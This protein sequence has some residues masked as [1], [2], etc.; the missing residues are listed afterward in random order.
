MHVG[1]ALYT[2]IIFGVRRPIRLDG[3]YTRKESRSKD[4]VHNRGVVVIFSLEWCVQPR[5]KISN[6]SLPEDVED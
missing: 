5:P 4:R 3:M 6:L 1:T 2:G